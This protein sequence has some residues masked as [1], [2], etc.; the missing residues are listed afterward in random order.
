VKRTFTASITH[1]GD[2]CI[3]QCLEEGRCRNHRG[4]HPEIKPRR[5]RP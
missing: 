2:W 5:S 3:A 1:E 4:V